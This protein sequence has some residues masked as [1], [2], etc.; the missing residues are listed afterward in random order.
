M[1]S[2]ERNAKLEAIFCNNEIVNSDT[3]A[4][5]DETEATVEHGPQLG[6]KAYY[7][8]SSKRTN[9]PA[10]LSVILRPKGKWQVTKIQTNHNHDLDPS[11]CRLMEGHMNLN[12]E[13]RINLEANDIVG[14]RPCKSNRLLEVQSGGPE[15]LTR[16]PKDCRNFIEEKGGRDS[17]K[18]KLSQSTNYS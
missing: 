3:K 17:V 8:K 9:C 12:H 10:R 18:L 4:S 13:V 16:L 14:I 11:M 6:K 5:T 7:E 1:E 2:G 15:N